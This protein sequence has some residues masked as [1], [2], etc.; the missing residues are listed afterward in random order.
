MSV[1]VSGYGAAHASGD[2]G[3]D[4]LAGNGSTPWRTRRR[5]LST[6]CRSRNLRAVRKHAPPQYWTPHSVCVASV[7]R[8]RRTPS[9]YRASHMLIAESE[10]RTRYLSTGHESC[11]LSTRC[12]LAYQ[13]LRLLLDLH[14]APSQTPPVL[15]S[16]VV[17][18]WFWYR[19]AL[20]QYRVGYLPTACGRQATECEYHTYQICTMPR[21]VPRYGTKVP[22]N[23]MRV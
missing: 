13:D 22:H 2:G 3:H 4:L 14:A 9:P 11:Y 7:R 21:D 10:T 18:L 17:R 19:H 8:Y 5:Y 23:G 12:G 6:A 20:C 15:H 1:P 16:S